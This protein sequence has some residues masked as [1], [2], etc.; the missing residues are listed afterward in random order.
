MKK[1]IPALLLCAALLF[2]F[3][4]AA[5]QG[6]SDREV[7]ALAATT[8]ALT[9][10]TTYWD[11]LDDYSTIEDHAGEIQ[12]VS[13]FAASFVNGA[14]TLPDASAR[15]NRRLRAMDG[16]QRYLSVV[17][18]VVEKKKST[19]KDTEILKKLLKNENS[20]RAHAKELIAMAVKYGF[21]GIEIDYEKIRTDMELW[22][23]FI[24]FEEILLE[25][26]AE[27]DLKVRI[28]LEPGTP[29]E[30][31]TFPE[32]AEYVLMCYNLHYNGSE[33]GPKADRPFLQT[34]AERFSSL[35][36]CSFALANGGYLW[37]GPTQAQQITAEEAA[38][39]AESRNITPTR[40]PDSAALCFTVEDQTVWYADE[41]TLAQWSAWLQ[42]VTLAPISISLWRL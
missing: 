15:M 29:V 41:Q 16:P 38:A 12:A 28:V 40:D 35:P 39:L 7:A 1:R 34:L 2:S 14:L 19:Q 26:A 21:T 23:K 11:C 22:E 37:F 9:V 42:E 4:T 33:P 3:S 24:R 8:P 5:A 13:V 30:K 17:N 10:W 32:G 18:D 20:S 6:A 36:N 25:L 31:L 27:K